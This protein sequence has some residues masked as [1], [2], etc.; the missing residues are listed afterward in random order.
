MSQFRPPSNPVL[1]TKARPI[2]MLS[3]KV[4]SQTL[5]M[6]KPSIQNDTYIYQVSSVCRYGAISLGTPWNPASGIRIL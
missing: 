5:L 2:T 3:S 1:L 4:D 6:T